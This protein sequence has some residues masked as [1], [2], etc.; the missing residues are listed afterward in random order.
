MMGDHISEACMVNSGVDVEPAVASQVVRGLALR[1]WLAVELHDAPRPMSVA[2]LVDRLG[3]HGL[4]VE[5]RASKTISDALRWEVRRGRVHKLARGIYAAGRL[6]R[7]TLH[8]M[9]QRIRAALNSSTRP[10]NAPAPDPAVAI[11]ALIWNAG[12]PPAYT[13]PAPASTYPG[14]EGQVGGRHPR[15][16]S[17]PRLPTLIEGAWFGALV[18]HGI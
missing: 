7:V 11:V 15:W 3:D 5:G 1:S 17:G 4:T 12:V 14:G 10:S 9:R 13:A 8:R 6:A 18:V 16:P 2:A